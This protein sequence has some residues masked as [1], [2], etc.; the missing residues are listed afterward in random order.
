M[1]IAGLPHAGGA[2][3]DRCYAVD[4]RTDSVVRLL[5]GLFTAIMKELCRRAWTHT[6]RVV[7]FERAMPQSRDASA[8][9]RVPCVAIARYQHRASL[10]STPS[11]HCQQVTNK[12]GPCILSCIAANERKPS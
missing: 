5:I 6:M 4:R 2:L 11:N 7:W 12:D 10:L 3:A 1:L 9:Q 8:M